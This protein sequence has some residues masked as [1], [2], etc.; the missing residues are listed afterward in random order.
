MLAGQ[1]LHTWYVII[2]AVHTL[3]SPFLKAAR[4]EEQR[5]I[6]HTFKAPY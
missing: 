2:V 5:G 4:Y 3:R 1:L 6:M